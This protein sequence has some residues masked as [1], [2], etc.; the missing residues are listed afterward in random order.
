VDFKASL[1]RIPKF[2]AIGHAEKMNLDNAMR[3]ALSGYLGGVDGG[4]YWVEKLSADW[5]DTFKVKYAIPCNSATSGLLA[6]CMAAG[7]GPG[8]TVW[9]PSYS[10]SATAACAKVL[11]ATVVFIDIE[12]TRFSMNMNNFTKT[13]PKAIIVTNLFGHPAYLSSM[14][15]WCDST[16]T[17]MIEDNAQSP[18]AM[19]NGHYAGTIGHIGVWSFN[20]HKAINAGEGGVVATNDSALSARIQGAINHGELGGTIE[21]GFNLRMTE[22]TAAIACAQL[23]KGPKIIEGR[24]E[25][26]LELTDMV[27]DIPWIIPPVEDVDC[28]H[29]YYIWA[30]RVQDNKR[31]VFCQMLSEDGIPIRAGYSPPLNRI[32]KSHQSCAVAQHLEDKELICFEVCGYSPRTQQMKKMRKIIQQTAEKLCH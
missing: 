17:I 9:A 14:R 23:A 11:G 19:E 6:A 10:M 25:L 2:N 29:V 16:N 31:D 4:G 21:A 20:I 5:C 18:F 30:A 15:S 3:H 24:R 32:F 26:A 22:P 7:I 12:T 27:K 8:D 13:P 1:G 28:R